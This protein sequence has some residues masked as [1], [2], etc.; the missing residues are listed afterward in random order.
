MYLNVFV[1]VVVV[2][3]WLHYFFLIPVALVKVCFH[4]KSPT[5]ILYP[6]YSFLSGYEIVIN[7]PK[8]SLL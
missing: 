2:F 4:E 5:V 6:E 1:V 8:I 7:C 3:S